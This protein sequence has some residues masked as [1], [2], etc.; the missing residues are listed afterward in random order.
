MA[1]IIRELSSLAVSK[2]RTEGAHAV[3]G[4]QGLQLQV[5]G[6]SKVWVLRFTLN[7]KR[8]RM[9]Q[10]SYPAVSLAEARE[11]ARQARLLVRAGVD[12]IEQRADERETRVAARAKSLTF[13]QAA[14]RFIAAHEDGWRN[15]KHRLQWVNTIATYAQPVIGKMHVANIEQ[16]HIL[17]VL[18]PIWRNKTE[19]ASRLRGRIE[20]G[21]I[22]QWYKA[23]ARDLTR[24]DGVIIL[25]CCFPHRKKWHPLSIWQ[26]FH[27]QRLGWFGNRSVLYQDQVHKHCN[28]R[29]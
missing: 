24:Q 4:V 8:R 11:A 27:F 14:E 6:G 7:G 13:S 12:P 20:Q 10:G 5:V 16:R 18:D 9:G 3:G 17:Q 22:G 29:S 26:Q 15:S 28:Y 2:L 19:T 25:I 21:L 1:K 23:I